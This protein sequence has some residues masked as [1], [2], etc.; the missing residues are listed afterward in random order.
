M[1]EV[2]NFAASAELTMS[3]L[4]IAELT[5]KRHDHVMADIRSMLG[6]LQLRA[7]SFRGTYQDV[8]GKQRPCFHLPKRETLILVS[9]YDVHLRARI[10]DR[11]DELEEKTRQH[12]IDVNDPDQ[13]I[14][15]LLAYAKRAKNAETELVVARPKVAALDRI[16][17]TK[18]EFVLTEAA[19]VL[20]K[21]R[22]EFILWLR[23]I[24]WIFQY[25][26]RSGKAG[27]WQSD[28]RKIKQ[29]FLVHRVHTFVNKR[30]GDE[31]CSFQVLVTA[32]GITKLGLLLGVDVRQLN[33]NL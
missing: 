4:E 22:Q 15:V 19:K 12:V 9:G 14:P 20:Q 17:A 24:G 31:D 33:L 3:S 7:P 30:T 18:G 32:A 29:G 28:S 25:V 5:G 26:K 11:W 21:P 10:I 1:N 2:M 23:D 13:L 27:P 8:Q 16:S 6:E